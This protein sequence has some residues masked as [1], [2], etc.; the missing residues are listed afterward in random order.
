MQIKH[1]FILGTRP[2]V[3]KFAPLIKK[4]ENFCIIN[5]GQQKELT[6]TAL[7]IFKITPDLDL[8]LMKA[9]QT[10]LQFITNCI[11]VLEKILLEMKPEYIWVQG[12]TST[13]YCGALVGSLLKIKVI[14]L[15]AGLRSYDKTQPFP[16]EIF[17]RSIDDMSD[18]QFCP[19]KHNYS[20]L[21]LERIRGNAHVTG[22][23]IVEALELIKP[24]LSDVRPMKPEYILVTIHRREAIGEPM[25]EM[26]K[27]LEKISHVIPIVLPV[28]LNPGVQKALEG[29]KLNFMQPLNYME[30]LW[31]LKHCKFVITDSGGVQE[32][33]PSFHKPVL[34]VRNVTE[35][36]ELIESGQGKL[37]GWDCAEISSCVS[38]LLNKPKV[39]NLMAKGRNPFGDTTATDKI[40][41]ILKIYDNKCTKQGL[42]NISNV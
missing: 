40:I 15:E 38:D 29:S 37:V 19:T 5:T 28:H 17:R 23:T 4:I 32:E 24:E 6:D 36:Q 30:F 34:V 22:N 10:P 3:I 13:A 18:I 14:H 26:F 35:R 20:N 27:I 41:D 25:K 42:C 8:Q 39:Y 21:Y 31:Y 2:E 16:E 12:D 1:C 9:N 33:A 11:V 7:K